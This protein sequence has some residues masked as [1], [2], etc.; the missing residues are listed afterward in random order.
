[1]AG[2]PVTLFKGVTSMT[3][4]SPGPQVPLP[5]SCR[6]MPSPIWLSPTKVRLPFAS[7][8]LQTR[9]GGARQMA[10]P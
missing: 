7:S 6:T 5:P 1:M 9:I 4:K 3:P 8:G 2:T 10:A